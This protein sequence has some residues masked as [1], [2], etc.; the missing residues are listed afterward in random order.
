MSPDWYVLGLDWWVSRRGWEQG[1]FKMF[2]AEGSPQGT[3][4]SI[5]N[6][7]EKDSPTHGGAQEGRRPQALMGGEHCRLLAGWRGMCGNLRTDELA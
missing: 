7:L 6:T 3:E 1:G 4:L 5:P 2:E